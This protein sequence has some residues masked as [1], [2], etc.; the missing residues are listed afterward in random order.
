MKGS[1]THAKSYSTKSATWGTYKQDYTGWYVV[2]VRQTEVISGNTTGQQ[3]AILKRRTELV[4]TA[5]NYEWIS[6]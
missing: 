1:E 5:I 3:P 2:T 4:T 6:R